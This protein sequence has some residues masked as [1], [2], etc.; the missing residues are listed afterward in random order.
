MEEE[1]VTIK[2]TENGV[3]REGGL[4]QRMWSSSDCF[5]V[6]LVSGD[7]QRVMAHKAVLASCSPLLNSVLSGR[8]LANAQQVIFLH[9]TKTEVL[10]KLVEFCYL[11]KV[12]VQTVHLESFLNLGESLQLC[13]LKTK[14]GAKDPVK[15]E[16]KEEEPEKGIDI[17]WSNSQQQDMVET[18]HWRACHLPSRFREAVSKKHAKKLAA[19]F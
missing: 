10:R 14:G 5:D 4:L 7:G 8:G 18:N 6:T 12:S 16:V 15:E 19:E 13:E 9:E 1:L 17:I 2:S 3:S 11:G